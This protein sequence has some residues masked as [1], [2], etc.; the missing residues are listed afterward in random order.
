MIGKTAE[1]VG[2]AWFK[3]LLY[4]FLIF[5]VYP[6]YTKGLSFVLSARNHSSDTQVISNK[7]KETDGFTR[8]AWFPEK[9]PTSF[10]INEKQAL[11]AKELVK[12]RPLSSLNVGSY[13]LFNYIHD[14]EFLSWYKFFGIN[15]LVLGENPRIKD[16]NEEEKLNSEDIKNRVATVSG[17]IKKDWGVETPVY[18]VPDS[19]P[20]MMTT[21]KMLGIVGPDNL[22]ITPEKALPAI[23]FE[24]GKFDPS[25]LQGISPDALSLIFNGDVIKWSAIPSSPLT[26]SCR[27]DVLFASFIVSIR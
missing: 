5:S 27:Y 8:V 20:R 6:L 10:H 13:D 25:N 21:E 12:L 22:S 7:I 18:E 2:K 17:L 24:D 16:L 26:M 4:A 23:Y 19:Y 3:A 1:V 15:Y 14:P 9:N 11:D